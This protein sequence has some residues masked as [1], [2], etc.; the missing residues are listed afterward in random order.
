MIM[1]KIKVGKEFN[2]K[3]LELFVFKIFPYL[4]KSTFYKALRKKDIRINDVKVSDNVNLNEGDEVTIYI[5]DELLLKPTF[6]VEIIYE[7]ENILIVNKPS[8]IEVTGENSLTSYL[9]EKLKIS[10]L[11]PC[12]RIDRNTLGLVLFAKNEESLNILLD[13][14]KNHEIEKHYLALCYGIP[15]NKEATLTAYLFKD[16]KKSMVYISPNKAKGYNQ[17]ITKYSLIG[18]KEY[19]VNGK[20]EKVSLLDVSIKTG[21]THQIRA[22]LAYLGLPIIG[23]GKYGINQVNKEFKQKTQMLESYKLKFVFTEDADILNYL[24]NKEFSI[25]K[26]KISLEIKY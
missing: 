10:Y 11:M 24:N 7:D 12:H 23:D 17:I 5:V 1:K 6:N 14:F 4:K 19:A 3:S 20:I 25:K 15:K 26:P 18:N 21:R 2:N 22:H 16:N 9:K 8:Q 13:K